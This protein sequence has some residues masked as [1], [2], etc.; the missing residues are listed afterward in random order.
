MIYFY[1]RPL[2]LSSDGFDS[3]ATSPERRDHILLDVSLYVIFNLALACHLVG[4]ETSNDFSSL[5]AKELYG[6]ILASSPPLG[7]TTSRDYLK[8]LVW[9]NLAHLHFEFCEYEH[10]RYYLECFGEMIRRT[11]CL[12]NDTSNDVLSDHEMDEL[13]LNLLLL[14]FFPVAAKAA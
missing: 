6:M 2:L 4:L 8:G 7:A 14:H 9:N 3:A 13:H 11:G 1:N 5:R 12:Q 10:A